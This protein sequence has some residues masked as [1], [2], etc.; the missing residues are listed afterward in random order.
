MGFASR[1]SK[2]STS[3]TSAVG[4]TRASRGFS[5]LPTLTTTHIHHHTCY[6]EKAS[7][8]FHVYFYV[9]STSALVAS[10]SMYISLP[11]PWEKKEYVVIL[12]F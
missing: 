3:H 1:Q 8:Y 5:L 9:R 12:N 2:E 11:V 4:C 6:H 7:T 10:V